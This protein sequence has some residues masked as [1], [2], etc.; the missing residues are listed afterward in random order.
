LVDQAHRKI[1][2]ALSRVQ[3]VLKTMVVGRAGEWW[4]SANAADTGM[5]VADEVDLLAVSVAGRF[6]P[7][8]CDVR[9]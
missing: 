9:L 1:G 4:E 7:V 6:G 5:S 8:G 2:L 3:R